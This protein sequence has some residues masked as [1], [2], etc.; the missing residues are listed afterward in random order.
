[1]Q[2]RKLKLSL[3][4][5]SILLA[6]VAGVSTANADETITMHGFVSAAWFMQDEQFYL[7]NGHAAALP[8]TSGSG[9]LS[10][11]DTRNSRFWWTIKG[12]ALSNGWT[13]TGRLELDFFGGFNGSSAY[14]SSQA[15]PRLR[16]VN[17]TLTNPDG[18]SSVTV[19]S[20]W[21][22]LFPIESVPTSLT[23][24]GVPLG[25]ATGMIGW[26]FPGIVWR[27]KLDQDGKFRLDVGAFSG[28]WNGPGSNTNFDTAGNVD[29]SPQLEG[30]LHYKSGD[31]MVYGSAYYSSQDLKGV[32]GASLAAGSP[33][34]KISSWATT[35]GTTWTPG[36][37]RVVA[38]AYAGKGVGQVFGTLAQ[39][40]DI[41]DKGAYVQ[42]GYKFAPHWSGNLSYAIDKPNTDDVIKWMGYGS[43]GRLKGQQIAASVIYGDGPFG[44]GL[45]FL[46]G[47][48]DVT[49]TGLDRISHDGNQFSVGAIYHF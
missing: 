12:P 4:L 43:S 10:G 27:N 32:D 48:M 33:T 14:S 11:M 16:Q 39:F 13:S 35:V 7:G 9:N 8:A 45:E 28:Q 40:G 36:P 23:H 3:C 1:M 29:F 47:T 41:A 22:L 31:L 30:R 34:D 24:I 42:G 37:W 19:G 26:R 15:T 20:Q 38:A 5:S 6:S 17:F 44:V 21:D 25:F 2:M 18:S 46:H 49:T